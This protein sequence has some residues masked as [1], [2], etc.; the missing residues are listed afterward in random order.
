MNNVQIF[1]SLSRELVEEILHYLRPEIFLPNDLIV[2]AGADGDCMYFLASGTVAVIS[3][4]GKEVKYYRKK[5][6]K[7]NFFSRF[8]IWKMVIILEKSAYFFQI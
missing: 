2:K 5:C 1:Q 4:S 7:P 3:P 8:V 6:K